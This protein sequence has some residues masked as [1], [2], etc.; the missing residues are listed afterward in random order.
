MNKTFDSLGLIVE[1][2]AVTTTAST[3]GA[4]INGLALGGASYVAV[5]NASALAGTFDAS[6]NYTVAVQVS[7]AIGGTYVTVGNVATILEAGQH[8]V[9][10]TSEQLESLVSGADYFRL[11]VTKV[12][13]TATGVTV[14]GFVSKV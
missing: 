14:T 5:I 9:G 2:Q 7:D 13:T 11:T 8:Q 12:G 6:N 3:T 10:F 1:G 4:N